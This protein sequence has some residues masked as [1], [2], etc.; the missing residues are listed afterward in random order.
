MAF[1]IVELFRLSDYLSSPLGAPNLVESSVRSDATGLAS[2]VRLKQS[3]ANGAPAGP[4]PFVLQVRVDPGLTIDTTT[5]VEPAVKTVRTIITSADFAARD[6]NTQ[7]YA[8]PLTTLGLEQAASRAASP[9]A[10]NVV[11]QM[12]QASADVLQAFGFGLATSNDIFRLPPILDA[13][14]A[15]DLA[16]QLNVAQYRVAIETFAE[17]VE[18]V[19]ADEGVTSKQIM[20]AVAADMA[21]GLPVNAYV[22]ENPGNATVDAVVVETTSVTS[23]YLNAPSATA[24]FP[25]DDGS[26]N[27]EEL[28]DGE[29][30][31]NAAL[32]GTINV[33]PQPADF[34]GDRTPN[35]SDSDDYD[36]ASSADADSDGIDDAS[37]NCVL[38]TPD[39]LGNNINLARAANPGQ[40][41][42]DGDAFGDSCDNDA[43][44]DG[45]NGDGSGGA[46]VN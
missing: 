9:T 8:T 36:P 28:L 42:E 46:S 39:D 26:I 21:D 43:D 4:G 45:A 5:G 35:A 2:G 17:I 18:Q 27:V 11:A 10:A 34:D 30:P 6:A 33:D 22:G 41:N 3:D 12:M 14:T 7:F 15:G 25:S 13:S 23:S 19:V 32:A 16:A 24:R 38:N 20:D 31:N 29:L 44:A 37:D 1:A 40:E